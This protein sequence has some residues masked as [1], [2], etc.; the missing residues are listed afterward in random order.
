MPPQKSVAVT[1]LHISPKPALQVQCA[2]TIVPDASH[3]I[4]HYTC[5]SLQHCK[6]PTCT[7]ILVENMLQTE[8]NR[9]ISLTENNTVNYAYGGT[10]KLTCFLLTI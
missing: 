4:Q 1:W 7:N 3:T 9:P 10:N 8:L 5:A 6:C 2:L